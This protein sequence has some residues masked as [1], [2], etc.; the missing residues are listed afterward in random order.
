MSSVRPRLLI[1]ATDPL[2]DPARV[3]AL[4]SVFDVH[5]VPDPAQIARRG[6]DLVLGRAEAMAP[7]RTG[8]VVDCLGDGAGEIAMNGEAVWMNARL[9]GMPHDVRRR[10]IDGC[11]EGLRQFNRGGPPGADHLRPLTFNFAANGM[12][13]EMLVSPASGSHTA[14]LRIE[15]AVGVLWDV[16]AGRKVEEKIEAIDSAGAELLRFDPEAIASMNVG[17]RLRLLE[18]KIVQAVRDILHFD[19]FEVRLL[20]RKTNRLELVISSGIPPLGIG[21]FLRSSIEGDGISGFVAATG[22]PYLCPDVSRDPRYRPGLPNAASS[23]TVP[24]VLHDRVVGVLNTESTRPAAYD[25]SDLRYAELFGRYIAMAMNILDLLVVERYTT[26]QQLSDNVLGE[27]RQPIEEITVRAQNLRER[28]VGDSEMRQSIDQIVEAIAD[29]RAR[30]QTCTAGPRT[31]LGAEQALQNA[32]RDPLLDGRRVLIADDEPLIRQTIRAVLS[33]RG[34]DVTLCRDGGG[35]IQAL[36]SAAASG[37][38][39][40]L[41]VSDVRMPD[42]NGYEVFR[43]SKAIFPDTPVILMTGFGYDPH[44]SIVRATQE[45]LHCFLFK[46]FQVGQLL[47][48]VYKALAPRESPIIG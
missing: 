17:D 36:E 45:G 44:H 39:F 2:V 7:S 34:A 8:T 15:S 16:T 27:L 4:R 43:A 21:E 28:Y 13:F 26:N 19:Q 24:L 23:L 32:S 3:E 22:Q 48:E 5:I 11:L 14:P 40:D 47:D 35:A 30:V 6:V 12:S 1:A 42:R 37:Q 41:V 31:I 38:R 33:Q 18:R 46:P 20:D 29:I 9:A 25:E 10:F